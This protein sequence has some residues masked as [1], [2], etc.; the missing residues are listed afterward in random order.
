MAEDNTF[1][2][3]NIGDS[4]AAPAAE[5]AQEAAPVEASPATPTAVETIV[6]N[7]SAEEHMRF[8][9]FATEPVTPV[10]EPVP[11]A[12]VPGAIPGAV[13]TTPAAAPLPVEAQLA[14][15]QQQINGAQ[16]VAQ[17]VQ[18]AAI[19]N[20]NAVPVEPQPVVPTEPDAEL[21]TM[22]GVYDN[23]QVPE[24]LLNAINSDDPSMQAQG[25]QAVM[26]GVARAVT[27]Q[28]HGHF[29]PQLASVDERIQTSI[30]NTIQAQSVFQDFYGAYPVLNNP[31]YLPLVQATMAQMKLEP[32]FA[33]AQYGPQLRDALA[34]RVAALLNTSP[35]GLRPKTGS[36][37]LQPG[38]PLI[39]GNAR[40]AGITEPVGDPASMM[41]ASLGADP[42]TRI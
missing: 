14:L 32:E 42:N 4:V 12:L 22:L 23:F 27:Q 34:A 38:G 36:V 17:P 41:F 26:I 9:P 13:P 29:T 11:A 40:P 21:N 28:L 25:M 30:N 31:A 5:P 20:Q 35:D 19:S 33:N 37:P 8:D 15:L 10:V 6:D 16:P 18:Q 2:P 24:Q 3:G 1:D 7:M 39:N